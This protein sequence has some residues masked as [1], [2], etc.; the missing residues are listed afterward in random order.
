MNV[1]FI[2]HLKH[3]KAHSNFPPSFLGPI[4]SEKKCINKKRKE[5]A[6]GFNKKKILSGVLHSMA[7]QTNKKA[8]ESF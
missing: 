1:T 4:T 3:P 5:E 2:I 6:H 8:T 7:G